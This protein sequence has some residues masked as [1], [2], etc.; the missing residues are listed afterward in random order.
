[1]ERALQASLSTMKERKPKAREAEVEEVLE[2]RKP[3]LHDAENFPTLGGASSSGID[4][5]TSQAGNKSDQIKTS[6]AD[7]LALANNM[8]VQ[9]GT[10]APDEFPDLKPKSVP[11]SNSLSSCASDKSVSKKTK[12]GS[13][14][15]GAALNVN[16][17]EEEFPELP[18]SKKPI[19]DPSGKWKKQDSV[20]KTADKPKVH[21]P[22]EKS[23]LSSIGKTMYNYS[24][25]PSLSGRSSKTKQPVNSKWFK[26]SDNP[27]NNK[28]VQKRDS[29]TEENVPISERFS[30]I[31]MLNSESPDN[32]VK[33]KKKKKKDKTESLKEKENIK[34]NAS[35]DNIAS[36]LLSHSNSSSFE[37]VNIVSNNVSSVE[38]SQSKVKETISLS[39][40]E[41]MPR[42]KKDEKHFKKEDKIEKKLE[43]EHSLSRQVD[44]EMPETDDTQGSA[45]V[46]FSIEDDFPSLGD[47]TKSGRNAPPGFAPEHKEKVLK[48]PPGL[49]KAQSSAPPPGF[50]VSNNMNDVYNKD[51]VLVA[52]HL[53][54]FEFTQPDGFS[55]RNKVL[56]ACIQA[57]CSD[58]ENTFADF[59]VLSGEFRKGEINAVLYYQR[60]Q[61]ILGKK[62]FAE[63]F[64]ELLALLPDIEK[65]HQLL[66]VFMEKEG[67]KKNDGVLKIS[68]KSRMAKGAWTLSE[69]G[70]LT[71]QTCR[72]VLLR[73]DYNPHVSFH[74]LDSDFPSLGCDIP[75]TGFGQGAWVKAK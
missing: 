61:E 20:S 51:S 39:N 35:L 40:E 50:G 42:K 41:K 30:P 26:S 4:I 24:D 68:G 17:A 43:A 8:S 14:Y 21:K 75:A 70:F 66:A 62:N 63:I 44:V 73:K 16:S 65:Q 12:S 52:S 2:D 33:N 36:M 53:S 72:Q 59:K 47:S 18:K 31:S 45:P 38:T 22:V 27:S 48:A 19:P 5:P 28:N 57:L 7:R 64:P 13:T 56:I 29:P 69:S 6:L 9:H 37:S 1:M 34:S 11:A 55:E 23:E 10:L 49:T 60:C 71:C 58:T 15:S 32:K 25:F 46:K 67:M 74:A 54:N 3:N